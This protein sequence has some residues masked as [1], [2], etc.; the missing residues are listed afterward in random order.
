MAENLQQQRKRLA[1]K[2]LARWRKRKL[3]L[4]MQPKQIQ[5]RFYDNVIAQLERLIEEKR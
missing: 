4:D 5:L 1:R 2:A 3:Y